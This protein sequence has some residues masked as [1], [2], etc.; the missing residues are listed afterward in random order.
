[1]RLVEG[2]ELDPVI[3]ALFPLSRAG[4]AL[5]EMEER[6]AFGK[7]VVLPDDVFRSLDHPAKR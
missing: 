5:E 6:R 2:G 3:H 4:E 7:V 1:M